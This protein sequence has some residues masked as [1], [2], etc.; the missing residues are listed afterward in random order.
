MPS[1][2]SLIDK[3]KQQKKNVVILPST[4]LSLCQSFVNLP[5]TE[6]KKAIIADASNVL[7]SKTDELSSSTILNDEHDQSPSTKSTTNRRSTRRRM[8]VIPSRST[9]LTQTIFSSNTCDDIYPA[10]KENQQSPIGTNQHR[11]SISKLSLTTPQQNSTTIIDDNVGKLLFTTPNETT[12]DHKQYWTVI[13]RQ[14]EWYKLTLQQPS[15]MITSTLSNYRTINNSAYERKKS[16]QNMPGNDRN[17]V[18]Q[19]ADTTQLITKTLMHDLD[20]DLD[21]NDIKMLND[22]NH[23]IKQNQFRELTEEEFE[24]AIIVLEFYTAE[25]IRQALKQRS[26]EGDDIVCDICL[27]PDAD[28]HNEMVFCERCNSCVHQACY[29]INFIPSGTWLCRA[30]SILR[31]PACLLC[32]RTVGPMKSNPSGTIWCHM[33]CA[34]WMPELKF[35][36]Y[37]KMEPVLNIDKIPHARWSL[38]CCVCNTTDGACIQCAYGKCRVPF[39]VTCAVAAGF[40]LDFRLSSGDDGGSQFDAYCSKHSDVVREETCDISLMSSKIPY[41]VYQRDLLKPTWTNEILSTFDNYIDREH[42]HR[43]LE[44]DVTISTMIYDYW[45][46]KRKYMN[47]NLPLVKR[48]NYVLDQRENSEL[49]LGQISNSLKILMKMKDFEKRSEIVQHKNDFISLSL[50]E[51]LNRIKEKLNIHSSII[52][53]SSRTQSS[54]SSSSSIS[55]SYTQCISLVHQQQLKIPAKRQLSLTSSS[56]KKDEQLQDQPDKYDITS[57]NQKKHRPT[58]YYSSKQKQLYANMKSCYVGLENTFTDIEPHITYLV[59]RTM[60]N[61]DQTILLPKNLFATNIINITEDDMMMA[62]EQPQLQKEITPPLQLSPSPPLVYSDVSNDSTD[63]D[64]KATTKLS[65]SLNETT[66]PR[67][68]QYVNKGNVIYCSTGGF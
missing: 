1:L 50:S 40:Y 37:I 59:A 23:Y 28:E 60:E 46:N 48:I 33:T 10:E 16:T 62:I 24:N 53:R 65:F 66:L 51:R 61:K 29:G 4:Q 42:L 45:F 54:S 9:S 11:K 31:R 30:C 2:P 63:D 55:H 22:I 41:T 36:E 8:S 13:D 27:L 44:Y 3:Q 25:K 43:E 17:E 18:N 38:R 47:N 19:P 32:P 52:P 20:Y 68:Q 21:D 14:S 39:H 6:A 67:G 35:A 26:C 57:K 7:L 12:T 56:M 58:I 15:T 49:L 64:V 34:L 5:L